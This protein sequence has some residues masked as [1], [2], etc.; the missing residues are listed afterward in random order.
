M[1]Q[2]EFHRRSLPE[3]LYEDTA[4]LKFALPIVALTAA[5]NMVGSPAV[6][7]DIPNALVGAWG[8]NLADCKNDAAAKG[9]VRISGSE[10]KYYEAR[11]TLTAVIEETPTRLVGEFA[12]EGEGQTWK[13]Q[14]VLDVQ[15]GGQTLITREYGAGAIPGAQKYSR[16]P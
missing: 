16:C 10:L 14:M 15:D 5:C 8:M 2:P 11:G 9:L 12:F 13:R 7:G 1:E 4:M 3:H 6:S